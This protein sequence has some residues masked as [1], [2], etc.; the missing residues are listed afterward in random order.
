[1]F[2]HLFSLELTNRDDTAEISHSLLSEFSE[3]QHCCCEILELIT[4]YTCHACAVGLQMVVVLWIY[5]T[6][7]AAL[8][9]RTRAS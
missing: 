1:M 7:T 5:V 6:V 2:C 4:Y 9:C 3:E 8:C